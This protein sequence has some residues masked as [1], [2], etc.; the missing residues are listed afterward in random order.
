M[1][2]KEIRVQNLRALVDQAN[3]IA[4]FARKHNGIDPTYISQLLNGHRA[5]GE[6]AA[7]NMEQK[8]GLS[9]GYFDHI[10]IINS[11][12]NED[13]AEYIVGRKVI[14][15]SELNENPDVYQIRRVQFQVE[16]G[17]SGYEICQVNDDGNPIFFR[18]NWLDSKG[19]KPEKLVAVYV[20]GDSMEPGLFNG[21]TVI[22]NT[23]DTEPKDG[24]VY[25]VNYE[26]ETVIKRLVRDAGVWWLSSDNPD[27]R[28]FQRKE[29][30]GELCSIIGRVVHKQSERI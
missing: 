20:H 16:A 1:E 13:A 2:T 28:R 5:F 17:I 7:R 26:S 11:S 19:Y 15:V 3:G 18:K 21:D 27:K 24:E 4:S 23:A 22:V 9:S 10:Q 12:V 30:I 29:C 8:I 6:K 25:A 14:A